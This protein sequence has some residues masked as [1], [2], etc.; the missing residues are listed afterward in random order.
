MT[1]KKITEIESFVVKIV[2]YEN[3]SLIITILYG[4]EQVK[5]TIKDQLVMVMEYTKLLTVERL[6]KTWD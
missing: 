2:A 4:L 3:G 6:G 5:I 1:N